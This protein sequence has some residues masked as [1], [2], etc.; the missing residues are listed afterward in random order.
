MGGT[1]LFDPEDKKFK[2]WY[3]VWNRHAYFNNLPF[4]YNVCYAESDDGIAWKRP[5]LG[6]FDYAGSFENNCIRL[7]TDKTQNIDVCLNPRP[8]AFPGKFI[9][10]HNQKGGVYV[11][12]SDDGYT[13]TRLVETPAIAYH[14]D[15]H[16]NL[17]YDETRSRWLIYCRPELYA[18]DHKRRVS[19]QSS[20]DLA[21]WTPERAILVPTETD[22]PEFYGLTVFRRGDLFFGLLQVY[23]RGTGLLY[24]ELRWSGDGE[25]WSCIPTHPPFVE[26]GPDGAWD[27]GMILLAESPVVVGDE[28]RFYYGGFP[29]PHDTKEENVGAIG[30]LTAERDRL[31]GVRPSSDGFGFVLTRAFDPRG[32]RLLVNAKV[33]GELRAELRGPRNKPI[34]GWTFE[35]CDPVTT[36]SFAEEV[37]WQG[38]SLGD[39]LHPEL[40][41]CLRL[42]RATIFTFELLN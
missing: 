9:A 5:F 29:L 19:F 12:T 17:V 37:T 18:G 38:R 22:K 30:L 2:M 8:D 16:N 1:V 35:E 24:P 26:L 42:S 7:G 28:M 14:S 40:A 21:R 6:V 15:T 3:S 27:A 32:K 39:A 31:I 41:V 25:H 23:D 36:S 13:F 34:P 20:E 11:S 4:S 10:I 33:D